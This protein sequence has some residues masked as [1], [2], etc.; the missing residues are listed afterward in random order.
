MKK[1]KYKQKL[2][3]IKEYT[4]IMDGIIKKAEYKN[5]NPGEIL[6]ELLNECSKYK[7]KKAT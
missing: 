7:I 1:Q 5:A 4:E 6:I 2:I 3:S